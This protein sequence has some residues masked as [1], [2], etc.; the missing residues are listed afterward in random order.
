[1]IYEMG[2]GWRKRDTYDVGDVD[3]N[4]RPAHFNVATTRFLNQSGEDGH[5]EGIY[6]NFHNDLSDTAAHVL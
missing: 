5:I 1:M 3:G 2:R 6:P 4:V